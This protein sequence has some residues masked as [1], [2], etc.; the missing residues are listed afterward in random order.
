MQKNRFALSVIVLFFV[1]LLWNGLLH[2]VLLADI[3]AS[4]QHLRRP[5]IQD[6]MWL[7]MLMTLALV[8]LFVW[9]YSRFVR[10]GSLFEAMQYGLFFALLAGLLVDLNQ[11]LLYPLQVIVPLAWFAGGIIEFLL[12][13]LL[14]TRLYPVSTVNKST[15]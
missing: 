3:N 14:L 10:K 12:Y 2:M 5:D 13:A 4:I 11:Y 9:G 8:V 1:A 7:S 6:F 15:S